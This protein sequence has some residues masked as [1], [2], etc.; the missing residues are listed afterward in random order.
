M[1]SIQE[2]LQSINETIENSKYNYLTLKNNKWTISH[3]GKE[4]KPV[5][6]EFINGP[7]NG[8]DSSN[9]V[10]S[11][12]QAYVIGKKIYPDYGP[13]QNFTE[14]ATVSQ[15]AIGDDSEGFKIGGNVRGGIY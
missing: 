9:H 7:V 14:D 2:R 6:R 12:E 11:S 3:N 4:F 10:I 13:N 5:E 1:K 15:R 8:N